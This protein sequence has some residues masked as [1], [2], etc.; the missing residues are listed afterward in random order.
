LKTLE[1]EKILDGLIFDFWHRLLQIRFRSR[2]SVSTFVDAH[3]NLS[4]AARITRSQTPKEP[5]G[6]RFHYMWVAMSAMD[7]RTWP[8]PTPI[9]IRGKRAHDEQFIEILVE[10][11]NDQHLCLLVQAFEFLEKYYKDSFGALGYLDTDLWSYN[12]R[13]RMRVP[14]IPTN[15]LSWFQAQVRKTIARHNID[16]ILKNLRTVFPQFAAK[17]KNKINLALW[18]DVATFFRHVIVHSQAQ[19]PEADLVRKLKDKT[20]HA[21]TPRSR[22]F[23]DLYSSILSYFENHDGTC[24][25]TLVESDRIKPPYHGIGDKFEQL[26]SKLASHACLSYAIALTHFGKRPFWEREPTHSHEF[27]YEEVISSSPRIGRRS[28]NN[29]PIKEGKRR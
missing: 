14:D 11:L 19:I 1:A 21:F 24:H 16:V 3:K 4:Y 25:L 18:F 9:T 10:N 20:G 15:D 28:E 29:H 23:A 2:F 22:K 12:N 7:V 27:E 5:W 17:E 8:K 26:I 13:G 6:H